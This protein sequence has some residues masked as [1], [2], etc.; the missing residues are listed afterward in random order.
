VQQISR[1][2]ADE[3]WRYA[4]WAED[5][6]SLY[7]GLHRLS[8]ELKKGAYL[9]ECLF[10]DQV[11]RDRVGGKA[12]GLLR[13][14]HVRRHLNQKY[15]TDLF[16]IPKYKLWGTDHYSGFLQRNGI[17]PQDLPYMDKAS[18]TAAFMKGTFT[19]EETEELRALFAHFRGKPVAVRSSGRFE[20][21]K[22]SGYYGRF[23]TEFLANR[24]DD[25]SDFQA[26]QE[27][28]KSVYASM[29]SDD[30]IAY[31]KEKKIND[32]DDWM[33]IVFQQ[34]VGKWRQIKGR[35]VFS[36]DVSGVMDQDPYRPE[37]YFAENFG[38]NT[39][40]MAGYNIHDV[41]AGRKTAYNPNMTYE[42]AYARCQALNPDSQIEELA[43]LT[44]H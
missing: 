41:N 8:P 11:L 21:R 23:S 30:A 31:R 4:G 17:T 5:P 20:Y 32:A 42:T 28:I 9:P 3:L 43:S 18:R 38:L 22:Q 25:D 26:F 19:E 33:G 24:K 1:P 16:E 6:G 12:V 40:T 37:V 29:W 44:Q 2:N 36:P 27:K 35:D 14:E 39:L 15:G 7:P 10:N 34:M 13:L